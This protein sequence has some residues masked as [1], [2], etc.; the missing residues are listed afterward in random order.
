M[1]SE[2]LAL[3]STMEGAPGELSFVFSLSDDLDYLRCFNYLA[4]EISFSNTLL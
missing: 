1:G 4:S 2:K 3:L